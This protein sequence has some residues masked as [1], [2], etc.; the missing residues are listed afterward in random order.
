VLDFGTVVPT[1]SG[2]NIHKREHRTRRF[3]DTDLSDSGEAS[4]EAF[5]ELEF[6][7][8]GQSGKRCLRATAR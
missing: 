4:I 8:A 3:S 7:I 1:A 2:N 5:S 6:W